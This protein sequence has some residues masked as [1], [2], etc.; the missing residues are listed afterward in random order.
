MGRILAPEHRQLWRDIHQSEE[1]VSKLLL[2]MEA[3]GETLAHNMPQLF[4]QPFDTLHPNLGTTPLYLLV[5]SR[6][7]IALYLELFGSIF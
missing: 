7:E 2:H 3:Y 4:T 6:D 1:G 5:K